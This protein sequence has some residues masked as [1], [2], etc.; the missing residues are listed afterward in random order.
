MKR[1]RVCQRGETATPA[2]VKK[3]GVHLKT[4]DL[5]NYRRWLSS[6]ESSLV[7]PKR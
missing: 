7:Y 2:L 6:I 4:M 3:A 1:E 5:K